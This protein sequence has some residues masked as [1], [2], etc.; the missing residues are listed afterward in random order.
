MKYSTEKMIALGGSEWIRGEMHRIYFNSNVTA[1]LIK[2]E[3]CLR[4]SRVCSAILNG[5]GISNAKGQELLSALDFG[6]I[7]FDLA[8]GKFHG[9]N[10]SDELF[11]KIVAAIQAATEN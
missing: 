1:E 8:D 9:K 6:K 7:W 2:F 3:Y 11:E 5:E 4:K 10:I